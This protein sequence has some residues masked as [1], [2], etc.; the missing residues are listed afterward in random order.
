MQHITSYIY[1]QTH[2]RNNTYRTTNKHSRGW[3]SRTDCAAA[4]CCCCWCQ[5]TDT[6]HTGLGG[7][8]HLSVV[9][10]GLPSLQWGGV[11]R[12]GAGPRLRHGC[13]VFASLAAASHLYVSPP[14][15][16]YLSSRSPC[17][18]ATVSFSKRATQAR[19]PL[20]CSLCASPPPVLPSLSRW[21]RRWWLSRCQVNDPPARPPY[22][23]SV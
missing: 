8:A 9:G 12:V 7:G 14:P 5:T 19:P 18:R 21:L 6:Q 23:S 20:V 11:R 1:Y 17:E 15:W 10:K 2:F 4:A 13:I 3:V 22:N 16:Y